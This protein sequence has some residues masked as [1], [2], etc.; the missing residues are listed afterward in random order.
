MSHSRQDF[1]GVKSQTP[2]KSLSSN[3]EDSD[4]PIPIYPPADPFSSFHDGAMY[5]VTYSPLN[6]ILLSHQTSPGG[7]ESDRNDDIQSLLA[8]DDDLKYGIK[9]NTDTSSHQQA[10]VN[11]EKASL[12]SDGTPSG[13]EAGRRPHQVLFSYKDPGNEHKPE[14]DEDTHSVQSAEDDIES[15]IESN[16]GVTGYQQA[17]L[18]Y[19]STIFTRNLDLVSLRGNPIPSMGRVE[20]VR[21]HHRLLEVLLLDLR[22]EVGPDFSQKLAA[23]LLRTR[24]RRDFLSLGIFNLARSFGSGLQENIRLLLLQKRDSVLSLDRL[25]RDAEGLTSD[26]KLEYND[27]TECEDTEQITRLTLK[28]AAEFLTSGQPFQR[29]KESLHRF[30]F[31]ETQRME[32]QDKLILDQQ[33]ERTKR[34]DLHDFEY[35]YSFSRGLLSAI[36]IAFK[37]SVE[38]IAGRPLSWWPLSDPEENLQPGYTRVY[39]TPSTSPHGRAWCFYDDIPSRLAEKLFPTL[40]IAR[41][42]VPRGWV[43]LR[44]DAVFLRRTTLLRVIIHHQPGFNE[45]TKSPGSRRKTKGKGKTASKSNLGGGGGT[46]NAPAL[47]GGAKGAQRRGGST[48]PLVGESS[49]GQ[50]DRD[51]ENEED[52]SSER[53]KRDRRFLFLSAD[54]MS[55]HSVACPVNLGDDDKGT[56]H[57]LRAI[58]QRFP[59][60]LWTRP[61]GIRFYRVCS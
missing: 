43:A 30:I 4:A 61:T 11:S 16:F 44:H 14:E 19:L 57:N 35:N 1:P 29:Y 22:S 9:P 37:K 7:E 5:Q 54:T 17:G 38:R 23:Q 8:M 58:Y 53:Q 59:A 25:L 28:D 13:Q 10:A 52:T 49:S 27:N 32:P 15:R 42:S 45:R 50:M 21:N 47:T 60:R 31:S 12:V 3:P 18:D 39:S 20:F 56:F 36:G 46:L 40:S 51:I 41:A 24:S 55:N 6:P 34:N 2:I 48:K 26:E 33:T